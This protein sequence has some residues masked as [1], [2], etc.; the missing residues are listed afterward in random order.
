MCVE[1]DKIDLLFRLS[2]NGECKFIKNIVSFDV[3]EES[4][5]QEAKELGLTLY[6]Y[7][8]IIN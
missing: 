1:K 4:K 7:N 2:K 8:E 5:R 6:H 3:F